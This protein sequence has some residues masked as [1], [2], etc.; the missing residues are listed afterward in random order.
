MLSLSSLSNAHRMLIKCSHWAHYQV[1]TQTLFKNLKYM[2]HKLD[3]PTVSG[4]FGKICFGG[5]QDH[6][7]FWSWGWVGLWLTTARALLGNTSWKKNVFFRALPELPLPPPPL[8][9]GNLYIFFGRQ[10]GIYKV[11][12]LIRARPSPPPHSG[13]A[14]KKTFFF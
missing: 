14:R 12:F 9:S 10:K 11:Y 3:R 7:F 4:Q 5:S 1:W 6:A 8:L 2:Y 13:N